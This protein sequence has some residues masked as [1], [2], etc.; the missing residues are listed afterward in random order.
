M[1][2]D[3][4]GTTSIGLGVL[5]L[6]KVAWGGRPGAIVEDNPTSSDFGRIQVGNTRVDIWGGFQP[7]AR[8][9]ARVAM[10]QRKSTGTERISELD[11]G[12]V[13]AEV[14][15]FV[16]QKFSPIVGFGVD[17]FR[18][19]TFTGD[20]ITTG[21]TDLRREAIARFV[22]LFIQD[23]KESIEADGLAGGMLATPSFFGTS[24]ISYQTVAEVSKRDFKNP[25]TGAAKAEFQE[26]PPFLQDYVHSLNSYETSR[27]DNEFSDNLERIDRDFYT[28]LTAILADPD[29]TDSQKISNYYNKNSERASERK[30]AFDTEYGGFS[31]RDPLNP[32]EEALND[33]Y[34]A[35]AIAGA[36][37]L[38]F[39]NQLYKEIIKDL[40]ADWT[41]EQKLWVEANT[42]NVDIPDG[43][44]DLLPDEQ[45]ERRA[46]SEKARDQMV[47]EWAK[48]PE[49][50]EAQM[51]ADAITEDFA[52][53]SIAGKTYRQQEDLTEFYADRPGLGEGKAPPLDIKPPPKPLQRKLPGRAAFPSGR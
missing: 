2:R 46:Q 48:S 47:D 25:Y 20:E 16:Q 43:I 7:L 32:N 49:E 13:A 30:G 44:I 28:E 3:F 14:G 33:Y 4:V 18:G 21:G 50:V 10:R 12:E 42:N 31:E 29:L 40:E 39:K 27:R 24:V 8:T 11:S 37:G 1:V 51:K 26:L 38:P 6:A 45:K 22:P 23:L 5:A 36:E 19:E 17:V 34:K 52:K 41:P 53:G 9:I 35:G 15:R